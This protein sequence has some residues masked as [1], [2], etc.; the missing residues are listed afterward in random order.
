MADEKPLSDV[1]TVKNFFEMSSQ[2]AVQE[3][4]KLP[5]EDRKQI[6]DGIR[7]GSFTY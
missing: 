3:L 5:T 2:E 4:K 1:M 6:A 7:D